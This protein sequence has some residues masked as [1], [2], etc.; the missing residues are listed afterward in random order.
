[1]RAPVWTLPLCCGSDRWLTV[2]YSLIIYVDVDAPRKGNSL[3]FH[4]TADEQIVLTGCGQADDT[5][6]QSIHLYFA[7]SSSALW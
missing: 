2:Y 4:R 7:A 6:H 5:G 1:M 3:S